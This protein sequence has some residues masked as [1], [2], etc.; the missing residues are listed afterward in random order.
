MTD[1]RQ[2]GPEK[3]VREV[4]AELD[5]LWRRALEDVAERTG[6]TVVDVAWELTGRAESV[7]EAAENIEMALSS[8][9][10]L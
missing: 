7:V 6:R 9:V 10:V 5:I 2:L 1:L 8:R 3:F 4:I